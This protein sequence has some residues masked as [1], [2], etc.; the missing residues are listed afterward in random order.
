M[1]KLFYPGFCHNEKRKRE[2]TAKSVAF[3]HP[4]HDQMMDIPRFGFFSI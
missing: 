4:L 3:F 2:Q 1:G